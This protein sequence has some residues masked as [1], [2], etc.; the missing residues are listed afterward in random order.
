MG[1]RKRSGSWQR[2]NTRVCT[3]RRST[4]QSVFAVQQAVPALDALEGIVGRALLVETKVVLVGL[5][6]LELVNISPDNDA[7]V[8]GRGSMSDL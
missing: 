1:V 6:V 7:D 3:G 2:E 8:W 4:L 5:F